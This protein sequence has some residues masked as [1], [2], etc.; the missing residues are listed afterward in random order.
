MCLYVFDFLVWRRVKQEE[1]DYVTASQLVDMIANM[2]CGADYEGAPLSAPGGMTHQQMDAGLRDMI[3]SGERAVDVDVRNRG[4][5]SQRPVVQHQSVSWS[6]VTN[7]FVT[8]RERTCVKVVR[9][10][11]PFFPSLSRTEGVQQSSIKPSLFF[12]D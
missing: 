7:P 6:P 12:C 1:D 4:F 5:L 9:L 11:P 8:P 2:E 10:A 3:F